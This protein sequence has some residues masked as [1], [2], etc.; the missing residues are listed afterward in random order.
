MGRHGPA[1]RYARIN[2]EKAKSD[3]KFYQVS[4]SKDHL[5]Q[6]V[7]AAHRTADKQLKLLE[8]ARDVEKGLQAQIVS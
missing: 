2:T 7:K 4:Q 8:K 3:N 5:E 1:T 6:E